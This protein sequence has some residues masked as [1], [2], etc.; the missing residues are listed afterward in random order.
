MEANIKVLSVS[1]YI[2][3]RS[4]RIKPFTACPPTLVW[5]FCTSLSWKLQD[6]T[7]TKDE[8]FGIFLSASLSDEGGL[9]VGVADL[10]NCYLS[11]L[12][13]VLVFDVCW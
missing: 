9:T 3:C 13:F 1:E 7:E 12:R 4:D 6:L 5:K 2:L 11:V 10:I 8:L